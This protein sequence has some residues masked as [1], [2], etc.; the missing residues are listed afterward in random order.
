MSGITPALL[1]AACTG[2]APSGDQT[3]Q[4]DYANITA[5]LASG[6]P[7]VLQ[8]GAFRV[9]GVLEIPAGAVLAGPGPQA[10]TITMAAGADLPALAAT[11]GWAASANT[12]A[13]A[14]CRISGITFDG[15]AAAQASGAGHGLVLQT[16][17]SYVEDCAFTGTRGDGLRIDS[18]G[19]DGT[20]AV[21][22]TMPENRVLRC[23]FRFNGG[24]GIQVHDPTFQAATDGWIR[25][26]V[27]Q[28]PGANAMLVQPAAGWSIEGCHVYGGIPLSGIAAGHPYMTRIRGNYV[29]AWGQ[30]PAAGLYAGI[31]CGAGQASGVNDGGNGSVIAGNTLRI[32]T[33][34]PA[35]SSVIYGIGTYADGGDRASFA[36]A[37]NVI[38][39]S[40]PLPP[41][42]AAISLQ[43][44]SA[45]SA[46]AALL[47]AN[48]VTGTWPGG[49]L[50][51]S[52]P[53]TFT[54]GRGTA[55]LSA[56]TAAVADPSVAAGSLILLTAQDDRT[57]G[58]LR[59]AART[60][61]AGFTIAS[62]NP[63]DSGLVAWEI[64]A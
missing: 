52:G 12:S 24:N 23:Q 30:S 45:S 13:V 53:G 29:E 40:A 1:A 34:P 37:G 41:G 9:N 43:G 27:V 25:D 18:L 11:A 42:S 28:A 33:A 48:L 6:A 19:A 44:Q 21:A 26:C 32:E 59:A 50:A 46:T 5:L 49:N 20:T 47:A 3:G 39:A 56:G 4:G 62:S 16:Y 17:W 57:T 8:A 60:P 55:V 15:N 36:V 64:R 58:A 7:A 10:C 31:D 63:A 61:G 38:A 14:P 22:N 35:G 54:L 2:L 51:T